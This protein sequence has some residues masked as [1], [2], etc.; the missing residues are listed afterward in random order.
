MHAPIGADDNMI[1]D[2]SLLMRYMYFSTFI[3]HRLLNGHSG[4]FPQ[5]YIDF[6]KQTIDFPSAPSMAYL[7]GRGV[8]YVTWHVL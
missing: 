4:F 7:R 8:Q 5:S 1:D 6:L 2:G 3:W